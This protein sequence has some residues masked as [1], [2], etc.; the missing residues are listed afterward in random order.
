MIKQPDNIIKYLAT[1]SRK[2]TFPSTSLFFALH[3]SHKNGHNYIK[4]LYEAGVRNFVVD[5]TINN[6]ND[7][8]ILYVDDTLKALQNLAAHHRSKFHY[9]VIGITGSNGKTIVKEWLYQLLCADYNIVRSPRSYNSQI[10]VPLSVWQ[11]SNENT[12]AIFEAG[13]SM[14]GEM[15]MLEKIIRPTIGILTNI[16]EAHS[17]GFE[18]N[19]QKTYEKIKLFK[20]AKILFYNADDKNICKAITSDKHLE[21]FTFGFDVSATLRILSIK[22]FKTQTTITSQYQDKKIA[23]SIPFTDDASAQNAI[24][25]VCVLLYF[26]ID[27]NEIINRMKNLQPIEMRMQLVQATNDCSIINDSYSFDLNSFTIALDF[28]LQH[29]QH[30][31]KTVIISDLP[32]TENNKDYEEIAGM[33]SAKKITRVI[34]IGNHWYNHQNFLLNAIKQTEFYQTSEDFIHQLGPLQFKNEVILFKGARVFEFEKLVA[35]LEKKVHQT[36]MEINLSALAN[37]LKQYQQRIKPGTKLMAMVKAFGYGSGSAEIASVLQFHKA[38]YLAVAYADEGVELRK[39]GIRLP[40][41]VLNID[42]AAFEM[43]IQY[44]L[45]PEIFSFKIFN[46]FCTFLNRQGLQQYPVHIKI[47]SG[48]HRLGFEEHDLDE[49]ISLLQN[50]STIV[51]KSVFTHLAASEDAEENSFTQNQFDIFKRCCER[52]QSILPYNFLKHIANSAAIILHPETQLDLV[53]LGIGL[54]GINTANDNRFLLQTV[55]TLKT[56]IAQLRKLKA[57]ETVG[58][59]R[60]GKLNRDSVI[61]TIRIGYA[62]GFSRTLGNGRGCVFIKGILAPVIGAVSMDMTMI[63][64]TGITDIEEEDEVEIFGKNLPVEQIAEWCETIS[65]E[66][67]T[68]ISQRVKRVYIEE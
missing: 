38:D 41:L 39:A 19:L 58:Y 56:T 52:I 48:M 40:I 51:V 60:R 24:I 37:N 2:V 22:K 46:A 68:G 45:E 17:E 61:A 5:E 6:L 18:N 34:A 43:L 59:N 35:L 10:G 29:Q 54:Y 64:V 1:D 11:M 25:C 30:P 42:D 67:L 31:Q 3:T 21:A 57:G 32:S 28:L 65:Y 4:E 26:K 47:D 63:D 33:L 20:E 8:N 55:C 9:P 12:L 36:V 13:I 53:R 44:N 7:A 15:N 23:V 62:D 16:G 27:E 49:L 50:N 66:I 14:P